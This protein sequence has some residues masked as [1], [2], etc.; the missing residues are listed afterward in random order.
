[1]PALLLAGPSGALAATAATETAPTPATT[2][3]A[4]APTAPLRVVSVGGLGFEQIPSEA[5]QTSADAAYQQ[6]LTE[7]LA[8]G[9]A[10]ARL[11]ATDA[12]ATLGP[13]Q[14]ITEQGGYVECPGEVEYAGAQPDFAYAE[15]SYL[16]EPTPAP[17]AVARSTGAAPRKVR[18]K[19]KAKGRHKGPSKRGHGH[20][21]STAA[22][23]S[24]SASAAAATTCTLSANVTVSY[25]LM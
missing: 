1:M 12:D 22:S 17:E 2:E 11:L 3:T 5:D 19:A 18:H 24:A 15:G 23:A 4:P 13:A 8:D 9:L 16:A 6:A 20:A 25:E 7:A 14:E 10:K 21:A